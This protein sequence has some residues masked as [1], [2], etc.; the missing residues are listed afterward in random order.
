MSQMRKVRTHREE[1]RREEEEF[2]REEELQVFQL[3]RAMNEDSDDEDD[4]KK[5]QGFSD[6]SE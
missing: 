2:W 1:L 5:E 4:S 6:G 3:I